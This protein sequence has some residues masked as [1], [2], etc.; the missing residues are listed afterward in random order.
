MLSLREN[1]S[2]TAVPSLKAHPKRSSL[3]HSA[4]AP[5][6]H[7]EPTAIAKLI[8][9]TDNSETITR[10]LHTLTNWTPHLVHTVLKRLWNHGPKALQFFNI[11]DT[12]PFYA[13]SA[14]GFD[15]AIDIAARLRDYKTVWALVARMRSRKL[16][17]SPKTFAIIAERYV[18]SGKADKAVKVFLSMHEHGCSQ[19]LNSFNAFL[20]VLC[21][22]K[23]AEMAYKLFNI[24][25]GRFR[26]D[27]VSYNII[28]NG[29][30]LK[31]Q[32]PRALE[33]L[34]EMVERGLVPTLTTYNIMLKG[35]FRAGQ[36]EEAWGFFLQMKRRKVGID[37][38]TYTTVVHGLGVVGEV[39]KAR[40]VFDEMI[41][42]G[43]LP[44]VATFNALI[45][46]LCKKDNVENAIIV[47]EEMLRK[48]YTPNV[49]T[50]NVVI[51]GLCH[52]GNMDRAI[53]YMD[54]MKDDNC[55]PIVQTYNVVIR[56][57]C[58]DGEIE[59]AL[60][61]FERMTGGSCL[62]NL[63][64]Y[65]ILISVMFVRKRSDD[66]LV[67]GKLLIEMVDRGFLPRK[68]T[69]NRVLNGLLLT[70]NQ[71]FAK[72]ILSLQSRCGRL[73]RHFRL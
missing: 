34:K 27:T 47:F 32:T 72:E 62:P 15:H 12:H 23:R 44:S 30:C 20:D 48:G 5:P 71:G 35:Y 49:T 69:F 24:F 45:Q 42:A 40:K 18:S 13:H 51:R 11:L 63:D 9:K 73:P 58:D 22:S 8:L 67:A 38:V 52:A 4:T 31:K 3:H 16:G 59:K 68:F 54:K 36:I 64:T 56:Y 17:P 46:V 55:K 26:A 28:A 10:N 6:P 21:K 19:N 33:V 25:R 61:M 7:P 1:I 53:E 29:F 66:L 39:E 2:Q 43:V 41:G 65:N 50:Y 57:Y 37:V 70:G 14:T 60:A